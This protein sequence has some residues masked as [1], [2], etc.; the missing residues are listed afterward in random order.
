MPFTLAHAAA[1]LPLRRLN[2][3]WSAFVIGSFAP[4]FPYVIGSTKYRYWGHAFP[5]VLLFALPAS[6][7]AL[8]LF[9]RVLKKPVVGLFPVGFQQRLRPYLGNFEFGGF[10]RFFTI[11]A[12][13]ALGIALH[14]LWDSVTHPFTWP[15]R[16]SAFLRLW[17]TLPVVGWTPV[18]EVL[19][20]GSTVAGLVAIAVWVLLWYRDTTPMARAAPSHPRSRFSLALLIF[21][22]AAVAGLLRAAVLVGVPAGFKGC[23]EFML[24]FSVTFLAVAFWA[25]VLYCLLATTGVTSAA[26]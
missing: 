23:D 20:Y 4:D 24:V 15:W 5:G 21:A 9:H 12:S 6:L 11:V 3:I 17:V 22:A 19:Q 10:A 25:L 8:W 14:L 1:A 18:F 26:G 2:L 13:I 7:V 16:H